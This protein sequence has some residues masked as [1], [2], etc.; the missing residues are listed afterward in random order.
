MLE[1]HMTMYEYWKA[2]ADRQ[3]D[4]R[5]LG[6]P[7]YCL[8]AQECVS[9]I[10]RL[11]ARFS[12]LSIGPGDYVALRA[13]RNV[14]TILALFALRAIG[15][16][17][18]LT[19]PRQDPAEYLADSLVPIPV[20]A[21][22][23]QTAG[24][25][26][27]VTSDGAEE[28]FDILSLPPVSGAIEGADAFGPAFIIFTSGSTGL[29]KAVVLSESNLISNLID[30]GPLGLYLEDDIALGSVPVD[31]VFGLALLT[32]VVVH[33][34][35]L[36]L[37]EK[38]DLVSLL[39]TIERERI[40][41]MNGVPSLYLAMCD[42]KGDRDLSSLRAGFIGGSPV[43]EQQ[44]RYLEET[45][46]MTLVP[47]YGMSE[48]IGISC[49][50]WKD[51]VSVRASGVG[52]VYPM[53]TVVIRKEDGRNAAPMEE[54]EILVNGPMR[55][56]GYWGQKLEPDAFFATGDLGYLDEKGVLHISGRK[57]DIIIR[58]GN[59]LS[60]VRI[61]QA[62]L[63]LPGVKAAA[64]VGMPDRLQGEVPYA[65][66]EGKGTEASLLESLSGILQ[67]NE[68]PA[69]VLFGAIPKTA[70]GKPDKPRIRKEMEKCLPG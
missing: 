37:P 61:E 11:A 18:V 48:C 62:L 30:S 59:N 13:R 17:A 15:A 16:C 27:A 9:W 19:D 10:E 60:T 40:T 22:A 50:S 65:L 14:P 46:Q 70:S 3:P 49:A 29:K 21:F 57:K 25:E 64:V 67:K 52:P 69:R 4:K 41:R 1:N 5:M 51:P 24:M 7:S 39:D 32:G 33:G 47:V 28:R 35:T 58:N 20:K 6:D 68:L 38:T 44:F 34:Y 23:E 36:Y 43:T 45:L 42:Q 55:M 66:V 53:N 31:H 8:L 2:L 26:L 12:A 54:G 56:I 63:S